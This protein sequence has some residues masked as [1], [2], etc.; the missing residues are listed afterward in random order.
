MGVVCPVLQAQVLQCLRQHSPA[1][2]ARTAKENRE[3]AGVIVRT[4]SGRVLLREFAGHS[5]SL[6]VDPLC[7]QVCATSQQPPDPGQY[8]QQAHR[9]PD[10]EPGVPTDGLAPRPGS[11]VGRRCSASSTA[12]RW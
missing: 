6:S 8:R 1:L 4:A 9:L 2:L 11:R 12:I 10:P 5:Q 7:A 3:L